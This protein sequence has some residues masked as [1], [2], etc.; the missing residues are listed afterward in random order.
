MLIDPLFGVMAPELGWV[1]SPRFLLRRDRILRLLSGPSLGNLVEVG[2]GSGSILHELALR[3]EDA[4]GIETSSRAR[5]LAASIACSG[6]GKQRIV[7]A[8][9]S[10]WRRDRNLVCAFDVLE[11]IEHDDAAI[12]EWS[13]WLTKAGA[14]C[15]SVPAHQERWGAGDEWAGHWR[16]YDKSRLESLLAAN[17]FSIEHIECYGFPLGNLTEWYGER[18]YRRELLQRNGGVSK[19]EATGESGVDRNYYVKKFAWLD[20]RLGRMAFRLANAMQRLASRTDWGTGYLVLA[21]K[22]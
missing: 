7:E 12:A 8:P 4:V 17:G 11:H 6:R 19:A 10:E 3:S 2:C 18:F 13:S 15:I 5:A 1:P 20:S 22:L 14:L 16:R 9:D 21:R